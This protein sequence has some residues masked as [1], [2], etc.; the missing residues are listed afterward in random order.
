MFA[1][2]DAPLVS[3]VDGEPAAPPDFG[4]GQVH[5]GVFYG[6]MGLQ[7]GVL[8]IVVPKRAGGLRELCQAGPCRPALDAAAFV[9]GGV[10]VDG[11][12]QPRRGM[13]SSI[14]M[15][16]S[17]PRVVRVLWPGGP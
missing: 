1:D 9:G 16:S 5:D 14:A 3:A 6:V 17:F 13:V 11:C 10:L 4:T 12:P 8:C 15:D 7:G 2:R